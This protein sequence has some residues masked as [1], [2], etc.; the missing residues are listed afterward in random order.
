MGNIFL[1]WA[2][3]TVK[4]QEWINWKQLCRRFPAMKKCE[5]LWQYLHSVRESNGAGRSVVGSLKRDDYTMRLQLVE[6]ERSPNNS[7]TVFLEFKI[8]K[9]FR[10]KQRT[11]WIFVMCEETWARPERKLCFMPYQ[12]K[13]E[14]WMNRTNWKYLYPKKRDLW[15]QT[16][17][18]I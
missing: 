10:P 18:S 12:F 15:H 14:N 16:Y 17:R 11:S 4:P 7:L 13:K 9:D 6:R 8:A 5:G 3:S 1:I 2:I